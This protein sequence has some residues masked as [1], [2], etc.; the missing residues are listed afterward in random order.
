MKLRKELLGI[1][2]AFSMTGIIATSVNAN[3]Y[4][5]VYDQQEK[6]EQKINTLLQSEFISEEE[7]STLEHELTS[8]DQV[9]DSENRQGLLDLIAQSEAALAKVE[10]SVSSAEANAVKTEL[11]QVKTQLDALAKKSD[12]A[13]ITKD[14]QTQINE[15]TEKY[16]AVAG[17]KEIAP[18]RSLANEVTTLA[19]AVESHQKEL[20]SLVDKLKEDNKATD[21]LLKK[22]YLSESDKKD[23]TQNK[24]DN[25]TF[26][27]DADE[28]Q[29][30][31]ARQSTSAKLIENISQRQEATAKEFKD[32]ESK[33]KSLI[34][35]TTSLL[36]DGDLSE[37]ETKELTTAKTTLEE[38]LAL[39]DYKPGD[40]KDDFS[41]LDSQ[42]DSAKTNS[43]KRIADKKKEAEA[44]AKAEQEKKAKEQAA[45]AEQAKAEEANQASA[46]QATPSPSLVGEWYQAPAGYKFLKVESGKTY[47]QVKIPSNFSLIT[48]SEAQNYS[49]GHGNG[50]AKQ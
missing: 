18:V 24:A 40:L 46:N 6:Q 29:A 8:F 11:S 2:L 41:A 27:E 43:D 36:D 9:K 14:D 23:L 42:Y 19:K 22:D 16:Q 33:A 32:Y 1:I 12:E 13:F 7:Q 34:K 31:E 10:K 3:A 26:F 15:I 35:E 30:V 5:D 21:T 50:Y 49:P 48:V 45:A 25:Q 47:G 39:K 37:D 4:Q 44:A 38:T 17:T 20:I 28:K